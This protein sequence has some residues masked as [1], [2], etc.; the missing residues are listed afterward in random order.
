MIANSFDTHGNQCPL[1]TY[2]AYPCPQLC[3]RDISMCPP[4]NKPPACPADET[5]CVDGK[6]HATC[7]DDLVSV[8]ACPGAPDLVGKIYSCGNNNLHTN[9]ENFVVEKKADQ[10]AEACNKAANIQNVPTWTEN[11]E[12]A[13]WHECPAPYYG[14]LTF[15]EPVFIALYTFYG[16]CLVGL[17]LW[18]LYKKSREK[19][20]IFIVK[21]SPICAL[22]MKCITENQSQF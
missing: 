12:S 8:C 6:C 4:S 18:T 15:T 22:K 5:Y 17:I 13:M 20:Y 1:Q 3:V 10:S 9:I 11:P 2:R 7:A 14:E 16:S 21:L 19:V